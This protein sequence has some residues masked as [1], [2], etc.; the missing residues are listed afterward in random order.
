AAGDAGRPLLAELL[1][2]V[3]TV[4]QQLAELGAPEHAAAAFLL[5]GEIELRLG[6]SEAARRSIQSALELGRQLNADVVLYQA[7]TAE[8]LLLEPDAPDEAR[9]SFE[10]AVEHLE[11]L[12]ARA[13]A[14][15]LK[16]AVV[17]QGVNLYERIARLSL[18]LDGAR[19]AK[20][21]Q[22]D[23]FRWLERGKSR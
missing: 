21:R 4:A 18:G 22:K 19:V 1:A 3:G 5:R 13:R 23:A 7:H 2:D 14:D 8:G 17:G 11:R 10:Q 12:R 15:D 6:Q 9:A 20:Q 16:L